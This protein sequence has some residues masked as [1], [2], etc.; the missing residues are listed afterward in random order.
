[1]YNSA[2]S[3]VREN[4]E[5]RARARAQLSGNW[6]ISILVCFIFS[7]LAG[8][9]GAI[10]YIGWV[11]SILIIGPLT[12]GLTKFFISRVRLWPS[13]IETLFDGFKQFKSAFL[14]Y[15]IM[16][17][18]IFLWSLLL[19]IPGIIAQYKYS[20]SFYIMNDFPELSAMDTLR[21]SEEMMYG[22]KW[23][24]FILQL[25][26]IGWGLL[27]VLTLGIG[28]LWLVPYIEMTKANFYE[29][30]KREWEKKKNNAEYN[31]NI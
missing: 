23:K 29:D 21:L 7:L 31:N 15:L 10:P 6:G 20:L 11:G 27:C 30:V 1:M 5:L 24:L 19:V 17:I 14:V 4:S 2:N 8:T 22:Y 3:T 18:F 9:I 16:S 28:V 25:S 13:D 26:F 12:L